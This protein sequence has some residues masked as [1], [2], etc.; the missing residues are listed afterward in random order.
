M[1]TI[2]LF[3]STF[4]FASLGFSQQRIFECKTSLT[5]YGAF[6]IK[7]Q[8]GIDLE[9]ASVVAKHAVKKTAGNTSTFVKFNARPSN[10]KEKT[11][12]KDVV[13]K[14]GYILILPMAK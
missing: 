9:E 14:L 2:S 6:S 1:K 7:K 4:F 12:K 8:Q 5:S 3:L 11:I 13:Q 10:I